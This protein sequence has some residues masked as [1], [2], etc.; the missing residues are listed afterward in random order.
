VGLSWRSSSASEISCSRGDRRFDINAMF[1]EKMAR[2]MARR[3]GWRP[4]VGQHRELES[5]DRSVVSLRA[6]DACHSGVRHVRHQG[7]PRPMD[8]CW[9]AVADFRGSAGRANPSYTRRFA[10]S[11]AG[12]LVFAYSPRPVRTSWP[13]WTVQRPPWPGGWRICG[14]YEPSHAS[15]ETLPSRRRIT[16]HRASAAGT[17]PCRANRR[18]QPPPPGSQSSCATGP[19]E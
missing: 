16:G 12:G 9:P 18:G 5:K 10:E 19:P 7:D 11:P 4:V 14:R 3:Q 1:V 17:R 2:R 6:R 15:G 13:K 8:R